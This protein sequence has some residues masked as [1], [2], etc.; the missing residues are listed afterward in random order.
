MKFGIIISTNDPE[1]VWNAF[2]FGVTSLKA[3]HEAKVFLYG[4]GVESEGVKSKFNIR[5]QISLF[6]DNGGKILACESCLKIRPKTESKVCMIGHQKDLLEMVT[7]SDKI[8]T[9]G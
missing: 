5:E 2:R 8:L 4:R 3:R 9:F 7:D 6:C 1:T